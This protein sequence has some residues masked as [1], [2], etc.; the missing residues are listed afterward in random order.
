ML[1]DVRRADSGILQ[2][3]DLRGGDGLRYYGL[4]RSGRFGGNVR[5]GDVRSSILL[6]HTKRFFELNQS[7]RDVCVCLRGICLRPLVD[8]G[9]VA[10]FRSGSGTRNQVLWTLPL[11]ISE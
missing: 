11:G 5:G 6:R 2:I 9:R 4:R 10:V 1:K 7:A 8:L 3:A